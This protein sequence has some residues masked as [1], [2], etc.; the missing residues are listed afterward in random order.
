MLAIASVE[1]ES[2]ILPRNLVPHG[3]FKSTI[4]DKR[5][6]EYK[7]SWWRGDKQVVEP[8]QLRLAFGFIGSSGSDNYHTSMSADPH[9]LCS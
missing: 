8:R 1:V 7:R 2:S 9:T 6:S 4:V 3:A 5:H